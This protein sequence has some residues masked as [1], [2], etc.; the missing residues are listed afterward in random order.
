MR[1]QYISE[2]IVKVFSEIT[3]YLLLNRP[4]I[5]DSRLVF[6]TVLAVI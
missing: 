3:T 5:K 1:L 6:F 4:P 2:A